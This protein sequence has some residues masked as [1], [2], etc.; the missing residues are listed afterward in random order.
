M[1]NILDELG[2]KWKTL[3]KDQQMA[4]AQ[5]V[6][7]LRQYNQFISLM[8]NWDVM[9]ENL[10][11][12]ENSAG[13]LDKQA[14]IYAESWEAARDRVTAS[15]EA[16][17]DALLDDK[18]FIGLNNMFSGLLDSIGGFVH[19]IGGLKTIMIGAF[20]LLTSYLGNKL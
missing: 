20:G 9:Q 5:N 12:S 2:A 13:S 1:D 4:V 10:N 6:A 8:S 7:G 3:A 17:Y 11:R 14:D 18:F 19:E 15:A 16:I